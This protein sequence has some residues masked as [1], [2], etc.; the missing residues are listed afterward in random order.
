VVFIRFLAMGLISGAA[1]AAALLLRAWHVAP[2]DDFYEWSMSALIALDIGQFITVPVALL[3]LAWKAYRRGRDELKLPGLFLGVCTVVFG[4][5]VMRLGGSVAKWAEE[6]SGAGFG[7]RDVRALLGALNELSGVI[8]C[9]FGTLILVMRLLSIWGR[10]RKDS[11][12]ELK[13]RPRSM[14]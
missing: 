11:Q 1:I 13:D 6:S 14:C 4:V 7:D 3:V 12:G 9:I 8:T 10:H 2:T 5:I